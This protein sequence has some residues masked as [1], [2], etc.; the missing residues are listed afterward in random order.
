MLHDIGLSKITEK[1]L[2]NRGVLSKAE[3]MAREHHCYYGEE[4][5][6]KANLPEGVRNII[7]Q[8]HELFDGTGYPQGLKGSNIDEQA[9]GRHGWASL[10][11]QD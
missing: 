10:A 8:H 1:V 7:N 5:G 11:G 3:Q 4:I 2:R 9:L 6:K